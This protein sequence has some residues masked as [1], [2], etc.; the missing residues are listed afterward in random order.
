MGPVPLSQPDEGG[1]G[2]VL[3]KPITPGSPRSG[4]EASSQLRTLHGS[5]SVA[6]T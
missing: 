1:G 2:L 6:E 5:G 3:L 4:R